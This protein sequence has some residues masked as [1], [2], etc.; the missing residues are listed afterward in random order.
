MLTSWFMLF[1][2]LRIRSL[3]LTPIASERLRTV[4]GGSISACDLRVGARAARWPPRCLRR[5]RGPAATPPRR[6]SRAA[7][8]TGEVTRRSTARSLRL[9]RRPA[10]SAAEPSRLPAFLRSSSSS[11]GGGGPGGGASPARPR[12]VVG[13][14]RRGAA[15]GRGGRPALGAA[16]RGWPPRPP[17]ADRRVPLGGLE[18]VLRPPDFIR[19]IISS[20]VIDFSGRCCLGRRAD[21]P[22]RAGPARAPSR[23]GRRG[24]RGQGAAGPARALAIAIAA[25]GVAA[26]LLDG[27]RGGAWAGPAAGP[28]RASRPSSCGRIP[29]AT[30]TR[31]G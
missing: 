18:R 27:R 10:R 21:G 16:T 6:T 2:S 13:A 28:S 26:G 14:G 3:A 30:C 31:R 11:T 9:A 17:G 5:R 25:T 7:A 1:I 8:G 12:G 22:E 15:P 19:A 20:R 4:I 23:R 29:P 24:H